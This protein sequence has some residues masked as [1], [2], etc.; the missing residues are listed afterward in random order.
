LL[1]LHA[2]D[3]DRFAGAEEALDGAF[4]IGGAHVPTPLVLDRVSPRG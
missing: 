2:D 3:P 4:D 1:E